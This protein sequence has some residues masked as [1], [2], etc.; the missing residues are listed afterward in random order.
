MQNILRW[1]NLILILLTLLAYLTPYV[2]PVRFWPLSFFGLIYPWLLLLNFL[3]IL[4]WAIRRDGYVW[5]SVACILL[6]WGHV[7]RIIG[8]NIDNLPAEK[9]IGIYSFNTH[10]FKHV[11][12]LATPASVEDFAVI[13]EKNKVDIICI[14][15]FSSLEKLSQ[16]HAAFLKKEKGL[17]HVARESEQ[18]LAV[19]ST[20]PI[21][22]SQTVKFNA[23]NGYQITDVDI[24]GQIV[25]IFNI[26]LQSN[27]VSSIAEQ[28]ATKGD[29]KERE[30]WL[31]IR[32][33]AA[34]FKR[35]AQRRAVQA[36]EI[37]AQI[38]QSPY[39][40]VVVGD[41]NDV[42]QSYTYHVISRG[43][44]DAFRQSGTGF[45]FSYLG[46]IPALR[47]DYILTAP[48]FKV[49]AFDRHRT[50]FSDHRAVSVQ[51]L[52]REN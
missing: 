32:G 19:F 27:A 38:A 52:L 24:R 3:F 18:D 7:Q 17:K 4:F 33:M 6:G 35:A 16:P 30:T 14:Q 50:S 42:P 9:A 11:S 37:A 5:F 12:D 36:E 40:V 26:H 47:I 8:F 49:Q 21:K 45:G 23:S 46:R 29:L 39:P 41:F 43:L 20:F 44:Q 15:E 2:S 34:R 13:F 48:A 10:G 28:V 22:K 31:N 25:R 1:S 51:L